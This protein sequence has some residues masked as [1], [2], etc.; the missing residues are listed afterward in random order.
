MTD[1]TIADTLSR[2]A[3]TEEALLNTLVISKRQYKRAALVLNMQ[4]Y[5]WST[6]ILQETCTLML[7]HPKNSVL[8]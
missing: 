8:E 1:C 5:A 4:Q 2:I 6:T 7:I 3:K